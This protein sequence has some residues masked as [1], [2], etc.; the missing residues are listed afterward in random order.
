MNATVVSVTIKA[1]L[2]VLN[3]NCLDSI[4]STLASIEPDDLFNY[5]PKGIIFQ[6]FEL[7]QET[8]EVTISVNPTESEV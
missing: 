3:P 5:L 2:I 8:K 6:N 1:N 7:N 4:E